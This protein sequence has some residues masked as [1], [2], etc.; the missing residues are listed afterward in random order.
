[1]FGGV[2]SASLAADGANI[3]ILEERTEARIR[4]TVP[5][6]ATNG[7]SNPSFDFATTPALRLQIMGRHVDWTIGGSYT[8]TAANIGQGSLTE[9]TNYGGATTSLGWHDRHVQI[10]IQEDGTYGQVNFGF[11]APL[12]I[13]PPA[14]NQQKPPATTTLT[15][16]TPRTI[17][18]F[19]SQSQLPMI[20]QVNRHWTLSLTAGFLISGG[21]NFQSRNISEGGAASQ[22]LPYGLALVTYRIDKRDDAGLSI[23]GRHNDTALVADF[24]PLPAAGITPDPPTSAG[25]TAPIPLAFRGLTTDEGDASLTWRRNWSHYVDSMIEAGASLI[26]QRLAGGSISVLQ[27]PVKGWHPV[28]TAQITV[29]E[30]F[31]RGGVKG[32]VT[33]GV[34]LLP[35]FDF[36]SGSVIV[37]ITATVLSNVIEHKRTYILEAGVTRTTSLLESPPSTNLGGGVNGAG[38]Q[39]AAPGYTVVQGSVVA[40][41]ALS[42]RFDL[43]ASFHLAWQETDAQRFPGQATAQQTQPLTSM[44]GLVAFTYHE[45]PIHF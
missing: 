42:K 31:G 13:T 36:L 27:T 14:T 26:Q 35:S 20:W 18:Y 39:V 25:I 5:D 8:F 44:V 19:S 24:G 22:R 32:V 33:E 43:S 37:P 12:T 4:A 1:M 40:T 17:E 45:L 10:R 29:S 23:G 30:K 2:M 28:P 7:A 6:T 38:V 34:Y 41:Q 11:L 21:A 9:L 16:I 3:L 15:R